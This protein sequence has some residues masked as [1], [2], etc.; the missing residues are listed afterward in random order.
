M[1]YTITWFD[2]K[3]INIVHLKSICINI[4]IISNTLYYKR[5]LPPARPRQDWKKVRNFKIKH[6]SLYY[7]LFTFFSENKIRN[8]IGE[9]SV[10][11]FFLFTFSIFI[12]LNGRTIKIFSSIIHNRRNYKFKIENSTCIFRLYFWLFTNLI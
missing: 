11:I 4:I 8:P 3:Q 2:A 1:F 10:E 7:P 5:H 6:V 9:F 12:Y